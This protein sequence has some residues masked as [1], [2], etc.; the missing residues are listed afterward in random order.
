MCIILLLLQNYRNIKKKILKL[1]FYI[2]KTF[3]PENL[4]RKYH[5]KMLPRKRHPVYNLT[6]KWVTYRDTS[7]LKRIGANAVIHCQIIAKSAI[8]LM[9]YMCE[10]GRE[11]RRACNFLKNES[12]RFYAWIK[13]NDFDMDTSYP[14]FVF[15]ILLSDLC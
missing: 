2:N 12:S 1:K 13:M 5:Q 10:G 3:T 15:S 11:I 14:H 6:L 9:S 8:K 4:T 7:Y